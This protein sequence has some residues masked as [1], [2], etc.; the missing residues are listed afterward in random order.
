VDNV[1]HT[2]AGVCL[3]NA[4]YRRRVG[5]AAVPILA[6]ASNLP[7]VDALVV[8]SGSARSVLERRTFGHSLL[9][10]P[11]WI[12]LLSLLIRRFTPSLRLASILGMCALGAG[13]HL[14]LDFVNSFGIVLLWPLSDWR[15]ELA[16]VFIID[17]ILTGL[18]ALPLLLYA[19]RSW[20]PLLE[21]LSRVALVAVCAYLLLCAGSRRLAAGALDHE[22]ET[23]H[24]PPDME[25]LFPEPLGP[26]RWRGVLREGDVYHLYLVHSLSGRLEYYGWVRSQLEDPAVEAA[27]TSPLGRRL[28]RFFK[29]PVW[30]VSNSSGLAT[31][32][33]RDLRF[34]S[35]VLERGSIFVFRFTVDSGGRVSPGS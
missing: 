27:R 2:L 16:T 6:V 29:A 1:T 18:L 19:V 33:A 21:G 26:H 7:D 12:L 4:F 35:L 20:R 34:R 28:E 13:V 15:P 8:L 25:Y 3:A 11:F 9:L 5:P 22:A 24:R 30:E 14:L 23:F 10:L 17:F 31:V 32:S